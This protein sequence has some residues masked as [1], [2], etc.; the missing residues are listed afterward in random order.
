M[1]KKY[2]IIKTYGIGDEIKQNYNDGMSFQNIVENI[3]S[4]LPEGEDKITIRKIEYFI[5]KEKDS[6]K[7]SSITQDSVLLK[8]NLIEDEIWDLIDEV[9]NLWKIAK[10]QVYKNSL[11]Y[12]KTIRTSNMILQSA[13]SLVKELKAPAESLK[14][15]VKKQSLQILLEFGNSLSPEKKDEI[16]SLIGNF[17]DDG[18]RDKEGNDQSV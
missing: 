13:I 2:N 6:N 12:D 3:N 9:K 15:D 11:L 10:K 16:S 1:T 17:I 4:K 7:E 14:I 18:D 8:L 5:E